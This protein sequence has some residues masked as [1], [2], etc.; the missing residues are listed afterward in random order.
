[1]LPSFDIFHQYFGFT[2][3]P[4]LAPLRK[5]DAAASDI[6]WAGIVAGTT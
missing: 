2:N 3:I 5:N 4:V 1:M 6:S